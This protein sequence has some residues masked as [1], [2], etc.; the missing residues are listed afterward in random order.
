M[1][2]QVLAK[3]RGG[4]GNAEDVT[5]DAAGRFGGGSLSRDFAPYMEPCFF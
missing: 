2:A 5:I 4:G 1:L 3:W